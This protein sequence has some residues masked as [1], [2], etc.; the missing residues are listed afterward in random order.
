M[1]GFLLD[2]NVP[3]EFTRMRPNPNVLAW[4]DAQPLNSLFCSVVSLGE[5]RKGI[6]LQ[7]PGRRRAQLETWLEI[8]LHLLFG[9]RILP[10]TLPIAD[11]WGELAA[12]RQNA[13][14]PLHVPDG[15][16]AATALE[17]GLTLVTRNEK[18]F[19]DLDLPIFNPW[20]MT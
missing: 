19:I 7:A 10:V 14:R 2:T 6:A 8:D 13:G 11:R 16:I 15:Q 20:K 5:I 9:N 12:S 4:V 17:H 1:N 3:S 18:D